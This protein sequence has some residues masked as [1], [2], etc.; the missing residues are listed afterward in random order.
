V[1][2]INGSVR[3]HVGAAFAGSIAARTS[4]GS[5]RLEDPGGHVKSKTLKRNRGHIAFASPGEESWLRSTNG[6]ITVHVEQ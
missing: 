3:L 5:V 4:N 2:T 6:G 1:Q